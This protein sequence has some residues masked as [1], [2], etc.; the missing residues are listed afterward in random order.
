MTRWEKNYRC[1]TVTRPAEAIDREVLQYLRSLPREKPI[2]VAC[3]GGADSVYLLL[4]L[5]SLFDS[6]KERLHVLHFNHGIRG[7]DAEADANFV[8]KLARDLQVR[9]EVG[10]PREALSEDEAGL[11]DARYSWMRERYAD[12]DAGALALGHHADDLSESLLMGVLTGGGPAGLASPMP[13][14]RFSDGH[15]RMRPLLPLRRSQIET[16]LKTFHMPWREDAS[17]ADTRYTRNWLRMNIL[18]LLKEYMPQDILAAGQR[19]RQLMAEAI[20]AIDRQLESLQLE[21]GNP[22]SVNIQALLGQPAAIIRRGLNAWWIRH[23]PVTPLPKSITDALVSEIQSQHSDLN[24][25]LNPDLNLILSG[26]ILSLHRNFPVQTTPWT[27]AIIWQ[28]L[29]DPLSLPTGASLCASARELDPSSL[30]PAPYLSVNPSREAWLD[31]NPSE[32]LT[33]RKWQPGD[34]YRPLGAPGRRKLQD[35]F[36][37]AKLSAEQKL[38]LPVILNKDA[39]IVWVPGFPPAN[40]F[41]ICPESNSALQLTYKQHSTAFPDHY[42]G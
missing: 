17:N 37:D 25:N 15:V 30:K 22:E 6:E 10:R 16:A 39:E 35:L 27:N 2:L 19:T 3:S 29:F 18:P 7:A 20:E 28:N 31:L 33:V 21:T 9:A 1:F 38:S 12:L 8:M 14:K 34:K 13:V 36:T 42:G 11:R 24:L 41:R 23:Y 5:L 4:T 32:P 26:E 40:Q